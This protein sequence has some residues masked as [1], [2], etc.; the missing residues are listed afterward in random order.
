M[1]PNSITDDEIQTQDPIAKTDLI[2]RM[3]VD[4]LT[5]IEFESTS[6]SLESS[7]RSY[8]LENT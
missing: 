4:L 2:G 6:E 3:S 1:D 5:V 8:T 7:N